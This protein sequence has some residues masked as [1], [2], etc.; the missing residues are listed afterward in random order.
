MKRF[1]LLL[2]CISLLS[3][4]TACD[5]SRADEPLTPP[6]TNTEQ[7]K[8]EETKNEQ[9]EETNGEESSSGGNSSFKPITSGGNYTPNENYK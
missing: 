4:F 1:L 8:D 6:S 7:S 3:V 9:G 5:N 2:C